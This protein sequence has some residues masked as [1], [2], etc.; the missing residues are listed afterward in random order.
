MI[1][2]KIL[3]NKSFLVYGL[4]VTGI[5]A[6]KFLKR[7]WAPN[8]IAT[9]KSPNPAIKG[10]ICIPNISKITA[11]PIIQMSI[12][13]D[14]SNQEDIAEVSQELPARNLNNGSTA[15]ANTLKIV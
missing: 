15:F 6:I 9:E 12:F 13:K 2:S 1:F 11:K 10:P 5:S 7:S 8:A 4:G 3:K 14:F